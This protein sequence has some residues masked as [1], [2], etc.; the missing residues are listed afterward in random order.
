MSTPPWEKSSGG[1]DVSFAAEELLRRRRA[2]ASFLGFAKYRQPS[3]MQPQRHHKL[4]CD[5]LDEVER[6]EVDRLMV[7]M[8]P[9]SA[10]ALTLDTPIPT[11]AGWTTMGELRVGD[12]VFD[13]NGNTCRVTWVS[14]VWRDRPIYEVKTDCGDVIRADRDH[15]WLVRLCG[16]RE[17]FKIKETWELCRR[18]AKRPMIKRAGR[19]ELPD[20]DLPVDPYLLGVWLGDGTSSTMSITASVDD[21]PWLRAELGRL[22][23]QASDT[24]RPTLFRIN[25]VRSRFVSLGLINDPWHNTHGRK[26]IPVVYMR[27]GAGQRLALLQGLIDTDGTVCAKRGCATFCNTNLELALQVRELVRS[28]GVKAGWSEGRAMLNGKDCGPVYRISFYMAEAA[29][30]PRKRIL[31]RDQHRTPDTYI[32]VIEA[33]FADTVCIE[34]DSPSHL[35]LCGRSMTPTHNSTYC[36]VLFPEYFLGRNPQLSYIGAS[37]TAALAE[38]F[39][40]RVRNNFIDDQHRILF[41]NTVAGDSAAAGRWSTN[42]GGDFMAVGVGG[43]V[44]GS[45]ADV[46]GI[47]DPIRSREDADSD[48]IREKVWQWYQHDLLTRLKP[49]GRIILVGTRWHEADLHGRVLEMEPGRWKIIK[50]PMEALELDP[51]GREPGERL[52]PEWFTEQMVLDAKSDPRGWTSLYQQDPRPP[53]GAEF[54]RSWINRYEHWPA[55]S[56]KILM[57]DPSGGRDAKSDFTS[58]WVLALGRDHNI[59]VVDGVRARLNLTSR[60]DKLFELHQKWR[61]MQ[62]RYEHYGMQGDIEHIKSQMEARDYR[63]KITEV[64]GQVQKE[65]RIRRLIPWFEQGR[66]WFP[67][68]G[69]IRNVAPGVEEDIVKNFIEQEYAA[70]PVGKNDDSFDNLARLAEPSLT[71]PWPKA[72]D[73]QGAVE[74]LFFGV[75]DDVANY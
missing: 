45:R 68:A 21:Q 37:H 34:V 19:L 44:T 14:P 41:N 33:G 35:F 15:E 64:G 75:L 12:W 70:F 48:L 40:R 38:R 9:G 59:Y 5:A 55:K 13:E 16:K 56:N 39:G 6:G 65:A 54:K 25:G 3:D 72:Q 71:L 42:L 29:R 60:A 36:S 20:A 51:L 1:L 18:R 66:I 8:P 22:G 63:F 4:L 50:L 73:E 47:D 17:V 69:L 31:C 7:M 23:Y 30:M 74:E 58:M 67:K 43:S 53:E 26:H 49:G 28:L 52:W 32:D 61:P 2:R 10:K 46:I 62:V 24:S 11:P 27:A 57:V